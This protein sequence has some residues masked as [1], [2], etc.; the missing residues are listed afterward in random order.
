MGEFYIEECL[1]IFLGS[2]NTYLLSR[3]DTQ[4]IIANPHKQ[5]QVKILASSYNW[6]G[7]GGDFAFQGTII[8]VCR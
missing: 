4:T 8:N 5:K 6:L 7:G 1:K 2:E 3:L